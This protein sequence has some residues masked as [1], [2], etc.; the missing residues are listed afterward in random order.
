[1]RLYIRT[2]V[3]D[4]GEGRVGRGEW[5]GGQSPNN[6]RLITEIYCYRVTHR[7][8]YK[9]AEKRLAAAVRPLMMTNKRFAVRRT[10]QKLF[11]KTK[12]RVR[13]QTRKLVEWKI[14]DLLW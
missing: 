3:L 4:L 2:E 12:T 8:E 11:L 9:T 10:I 5:G 14:Q 1:V 6:I 7:D 13:W